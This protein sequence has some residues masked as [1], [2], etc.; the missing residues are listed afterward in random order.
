MLSKVRRQIAQ[1]TRFLLGND[2]VAL[3][4][5][6]RIVSSPRA[7]R[8]AMRYFLDNRHETASGEPR[9]RVAGYDIEFQPSYT[10][11]NHERLLQGVS[12]VLVESFVFPDFFSEHVRLNPGDVA[13]DLGANIGTASL[14]FARHVG[15]T[16]HVF[17][18]EPIM[19]DVCRRNIEA[20]GATNVTVVPLAVSNQ[21]GTVEF[22]LTD[23]CLDSMMSTSGAS[24]QPGQSKTVRT[25]RLDDWATEHRLQRVDFIKVDIEGAEEL[26][27]RGA[28]QLVKRFRPKWSISSYHTDFEGDPQHPK[29]RAL[30]KRWGYQVAEVGTQHLFAW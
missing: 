18:F 6:L 9:F 21:A 10:I 22:A 17:S 3:S 27:M 23:F 2:D 14:V 15:P 19:Q 5:R 24:S 26:A 4:D 16:G 25:I 29:L 8:A 1:R 13:I 12:Q 28:E 7:G 20:N 30:L 11:H